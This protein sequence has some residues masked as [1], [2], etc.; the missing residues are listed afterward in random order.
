VG[1]G[2]ARQ[3]K[4]RCVDL[5][6]EYS[7]DALQSAVFHFVE[8]FV[9]RQ[10]LPYQ[11]IRKYRPHLVGLSDRRPSKEYLSSTWRGRWG[12]ENE[13]DYYLHGGGCRLTH[14]ISG[15]QIEWDASNL[16]HFDPYWFVNW[17]EWFLRQD[18]TD[19]DAQIILMAVNEKDDQFRTR[20]FDILQQIYQAGKLYYY[21]DRTSKY[22][23][24]V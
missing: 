22:E 4:S 1:Y 19:Q 7:M 8:R 10:Q 5:V 11:V 18:V 14:T 9:E 2:F 13:W 23:L 3:H 21:P 12:Q 17:L 16:R 6:G 20:I 24:I 15:E